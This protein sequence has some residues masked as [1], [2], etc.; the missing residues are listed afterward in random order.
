[1]IAPALIT[2]WSQQCPWI[3]SAQVEQDLVLSRGLVEIYSDPL[4]TERLLFRGGTA[5]HK[6]VLQ[7]AVRY[8][9]DLDFVQ[10]HQ[11]PIGS[12]L[13]LLRERLNP[14]LGEPKNDISPRG[15]TLTY[16]FE[17]ELPPIIRLRLKIEIN[18]REH[19]CLLPIQQTQFAVDSRWFSGEA[20]LPIYATTELLGTK[21]RALYQRRKGRDLFDLWQAHRAGVLDAPAVASAFAHYMAAENHPVSTAEFIL[22]LAAKI[23]HA[24]FLSDTPPLLRPGVSYNP[25]EAYAWI[26]QELLPLVPHG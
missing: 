13:D 17:S 23:K 20:T 6:I 9:E 24:G 14:W 10:L 1:M 12:T 2:E 21:L 8:S 19:F 5:L 16:R 22:N 25:S 11:E 26:T 4:L 3:S 18:T 7:P 15:A